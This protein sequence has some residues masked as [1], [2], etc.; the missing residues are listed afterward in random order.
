MTMHAPAH[1]KLRVK[2]VGL[3]LTPPN[4]P[5]SLP[6]PLPLSPPSPPQP[7]PQPTQAAALFQKLTPFAAQHDALHVPV[8][9]AGDLNTTNIR[10]IGNIARAVLELSDQ[11]VHP[12]LFSA[13]ATRDP[14][15]LDT[16]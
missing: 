7:S 9:L 3:Q 6:L 15:Q 5:L 12:F 10:M 4:L 8:M 14:Q 1:A 2:L 13:Q 16:H 11:P